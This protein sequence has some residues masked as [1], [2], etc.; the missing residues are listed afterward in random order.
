MGYNGFYICENAGNNAFSYDNRL[1]KS[2]Y[3]PS[4]KKM[5]FEVNDIMNHIKC[6]DKIGFSEVQE[7]REINVFGLENFVYTEKDDKK[8]YIF[9]NHNH[10]FYFVASNMAKQ[11][12]YLSDKSCLEKYMIHFDQHKDMRVPNLSLEDFAKKNNLDTSFDN[13]LFLYTNYHLNVGNFIVPLKTN[14]FIK[15]VEI[16]DSIYTMDKLGRALDNYEGII[17]DIDLD[18]F[19]EDMSYIADDKKLDL[20]LKCYKK[21]DIITICTSPYF[22]EFERAKKY[23]KILIENFN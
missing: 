7:E 22:I 19:S 13:L 9:D 8:I 14:R 6:S 21:A 1:N 4:I 5:D 12:E 15:D 20:I 23:L 18:F 3:V 2:I 11:G 17:L 10:C 16:V